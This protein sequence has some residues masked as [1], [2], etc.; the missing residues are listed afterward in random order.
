MAQVVHLPIFLDESLAVKLVLIFV[1]RRSEWFSRSENIRQ[2]PLIV[3]LSG[4]KKSPASLFGR[5][6]HLRRRLLSNA[7][8]SAAQQHCKN[9]GHQH[10]VKSQPEYSSLN[11]P[12]AHDFFLHVAP[13]SVDWVWNPAV[14]ATPEGCLNSPACRR[15]KLRLYGLPGAGTPSEPTPR[16]AILGPDCHGTSRSR[17]PARPVR[18]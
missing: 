16:D 13:S 3:I 2:R 7:R 18:D 8:T 12:V 11:I 15:S 9:N 10:P 6:E 5:R 17:S 1:A 4:L 14:G